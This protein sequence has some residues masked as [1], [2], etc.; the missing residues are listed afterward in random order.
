ML[1]F[2]KQDLKIQFIIILPLFLLRIEKKSLSRWV[3]SIR[4]FFIFIFIF[5]GKKGLN[6]RLTKEPRIHS[7]NI[8]YRQGTVLGTVTLP[9]VGR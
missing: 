9:S 8:F 5:F 4:L 7:F 6:A 2:R 1:A 3:T